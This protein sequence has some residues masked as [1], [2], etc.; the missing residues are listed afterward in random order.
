MKVNKTIRKINKIKVDMIFFVELYCKSDIV[1]A[2]YLHTC[3]NFYQF[4]RK[5]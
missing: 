5:H 1:D 3:I 2:F 4:D